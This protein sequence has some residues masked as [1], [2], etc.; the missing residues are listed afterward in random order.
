M[1][2]YFCGNLV[3]NSWSV[4]DFI[5]FAIFV[6]MYIYMYLNSSW[7]SNAFLSIC[8]FY[9]SNSVLFIPRILELS[10]FIGV[11]LSLPVRNLAM[12]SYEIWMWLYICIYMYIY[13]LWKHIA[14]EF[15]GYKFKQH[16]HT[17]E[18]SYDSVLSVPILF[19][20]KPET[21]N[22]HLVSHSTVGTHGSNGTCH[23]AIIS[24]H[25]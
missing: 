24:R 10:I 15:I 7:Y 21:K 9:V 16:Y 17:I 5:G 19:S 4:S 11:V 1:L 22:R 13:W 3:L 2:M 25:D 23:H 14:V 6:C 12:Y 20:I 18:L 8:L